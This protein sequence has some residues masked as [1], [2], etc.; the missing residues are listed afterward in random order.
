M[1]ASGEGPATGPARPSTAIV[2]ASTPPRGPAGLDQT[3]DRL[4]GV[5]DRPRKVVDYRV[6]CG[7]TEKETAELLGVTAGPGQLPFDAVKQP[8]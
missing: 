8:D 3:L 4:A 6:V 1:W 2:S 7:L 5:D